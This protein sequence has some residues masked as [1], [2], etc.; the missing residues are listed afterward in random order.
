[1]VETC[2][3]ACKILSSEEYKKYAE[4]AFQWFTG[5]N[6]LKKSMLDSSGGVYDA[7][8]ENGI[9]KNQGAESL[10]SYLL[11]ATKLEEIN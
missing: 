1:M 11:A 2:V 7:I 9:N 3:D 6:I 8:T 5:K 10:L 4:E